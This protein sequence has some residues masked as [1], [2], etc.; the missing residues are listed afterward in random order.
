MSGE[1]VFDTRDASDSLLLSDDFEYCCPNKHLPISLG[2]NRLVNGG[3]IVIK[4]FGRENEGKLRKDAL[5]LD[6]EA[7]IH[8]IGLSASLFFSLLDIGHDAC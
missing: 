5:S 7:I 1:S 4:L 2:E 3:C 6:M 8:L